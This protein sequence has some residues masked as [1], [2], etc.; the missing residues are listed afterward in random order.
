M[1]SCK[2]KT[3]EGGK[4]KNKPFLGINDMVYIDFEIL[5]VWFRLHTVFSSALLSS[6]TLSPLMASP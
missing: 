6:Y 4:K 5:T 2:S 1:Q 3:G